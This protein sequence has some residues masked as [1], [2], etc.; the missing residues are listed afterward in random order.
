MNDS[1]STNR[2]IVVWNIDSNGAVCTPNDS[3]VSC[4][5]YHIP[6]PIIPKKWVFWMP[7]MFNVSHKIKA[8]TQLT[9]Y[10]NFTWIHMCTF[11]KWICVNTLNKVRPL[12]IVIPS[13]NIHVFSINTIFRHYAEKYL[14]YCSILVLINKLSNWS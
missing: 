5:L 4:L 9:I 13:H 11:A 2:V 6:D 7:I 14:A 3:I 8:H 12:L 10:S 1:L